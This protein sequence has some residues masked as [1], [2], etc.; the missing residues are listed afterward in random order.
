MKSH[1]KSAKAG[2]LALACFVSLLV[3]AQKNNGFPVQVKIENGIIEGLYDT[4]TG[5][6]VYFGIPFA[7]PPLGDLRWRAPQSVD[8]WKGVL[9]T[10]SFGPRPV[11]GIVF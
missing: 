4:K 3:A 9:P 7:K 5:L 6:Q 1:L 8:N 10:K 2:F 11:Q